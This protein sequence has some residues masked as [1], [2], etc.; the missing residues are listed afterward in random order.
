MKNGAEIW[1]RDYLTDAGDP[2]DGDFLLLFESPSVPFHP[3]DAPRG[4]RWW[5]GEIAVRDAEV[6][7]ARG[8]DFHNLATQ[9]LDRTDGST[10]AFSTHTRGGR[11]AILL[12]LANVRRGAKLVVTLREGREFGGAP[13]RW[14]PHRK[15][16]TGEATLALR[17][18]RRG[19]VAAQLPFDGYAD[20][21]TLRRIVADGELDVTF[22]VKDQGER[23]GDYYYMRVQQ[24][25]DAIAWSSP[26]WVGGSPK[27]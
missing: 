1:R 3:G 24:A 10:L 23:H 6:A 26:I 21:V 11:S 14:R 2:K 22:A 12:T 19:V 13:P 20:A 4:W 9:W 8:A 18:M 16:P 25:N 5:R 15:V 27:R 17:E 7:A